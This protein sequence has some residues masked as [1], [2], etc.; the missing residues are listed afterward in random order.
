[1]YRDL[2]AFRVSAGWEVTRHLFFEGEIDPE[3]MD[4][5]RE[6]LFSAVDTGRRRAIDLE[7]VPESLGGIYFELKV[8]NITPVYNEQTGSVDQH[9]DWDSPHYELKT[10]DRQKVVD[11]IERLM[12]QT[13]VLPEERIL[14]G[15]GIVDEPSESFR[16]ALKN[17]GPSEQLLE[18]IL[19][20]GNR[21]IQ[22]LTIDHPDIEPEMLRTIIASSTYKN[23]KKKAEILLNSKRYKKAHGLWT[24]DN[25]AR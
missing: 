20:K 9:Y 13:P 4:T 12:W 8:V 17:E 23:V 6:T 22:N 16:L 10:T 18:N 2:Q 14:K 11:E 1:M 3:T 24:N 15:Y 7:W 5:L 25:P 19:T 21:K